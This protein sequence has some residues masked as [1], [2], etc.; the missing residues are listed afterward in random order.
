MTT[1]IPLSTALTAEFVG[2]FMLVF[3]GAGASALGAGGLVGVAL[4]HGLALA[5]A[6]YAFGHISGGHV[7]PAVTVG[8]WLAGKMSARRAVSYVVFQ[9]AGAVVA[10]LALRFVLGGAVGGLGAT[11]LA[12]GLEVAGA[13]VVVTPAAGLALEAILTFFL[14]LAVLQ[15]AV[16][17]KAGQLAGL[18]IG[19]TF[20]FGILVGGPLTGASMNPARTLGPALVTGNFADLWIYM[21]GPLSGGAFAALL[22]RNAFGR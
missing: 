5:V 9:V 18:A 6:V 14:A 21:A 22:F 10:A 16:A 12:R 17:G 4:A 15:A 11:T 3:A 7:N 2:T 19:A 13:P 20:A 8:V 1:S